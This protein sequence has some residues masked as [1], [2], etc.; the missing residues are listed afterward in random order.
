MGALTERS[1]EQLPASGGSGGLQAALLNC[2][3]PIKISGSTCRGGLLKRHPNHDFRGYARYPVGASGQA[4]VLPGPRLRLDVPPFHPQ[5]GA[6]KERKSLG[7][8]CAFYQN[9]L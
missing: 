5:R 6:A 2:R 1:P 3:V 8:F 7:L 4:E 9:G